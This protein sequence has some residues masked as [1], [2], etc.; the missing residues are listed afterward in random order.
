MICPN[1]FMNV[2]MWEH[3]ILEKLF[4]AAKCTTLTTFDDDDDNNN[5]N[6]NNNKYEE[7]QNGCYILAFS[8]YDY[9]YSKREITRLCK[10]K[11]QFCYHAKK[12]C[13]LIHV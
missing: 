5:N 7:R 8:H 6:N 3:C 4:H 12:K 9:P 11:I 13:S 10:C 1:A 2:A